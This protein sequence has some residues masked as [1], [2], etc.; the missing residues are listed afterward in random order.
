M[1]FEISYRTKWNLTDPR[2]KFSRSFFVE[3]HEAP[4]GEEIEAVVRRVSEGDFGRASIKIEQYTFF[5]AES[6][7]KVGMPVYRL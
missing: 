2:S 4:S 5:A 7:K 3:H 6:L 1:V